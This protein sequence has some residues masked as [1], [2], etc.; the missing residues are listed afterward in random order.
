MTHLKP[1]SHDCLQF[2]LSWVLYIQQ[3][4]TPVDFFIAYK[5]SYNTAVH[6]QL[7]FI[8]IIHSKRVALLPDGTFHSQFD[9]RAAP[10]QE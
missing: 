7:L 2:I 1:P 6:M 5:T 8:Q 10:G 4:N 3:Y 9:S